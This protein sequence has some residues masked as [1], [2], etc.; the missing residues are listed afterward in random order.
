MK[1]VKFTKQHDERISRR[2]MQNHPEG[3]TIKLSDARADKLIAEGA[4]EE[5]SGEA[6]EET[7][8]A[9]APKAGETAKTV[10]VPHVK[11]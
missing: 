4:A 11:G 6:A 5:V 9:E 10:K 2:K 7:P 3:S 1:T 8:P